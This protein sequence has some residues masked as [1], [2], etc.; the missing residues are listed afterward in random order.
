M[1]E[2]G[3]G[4]PAEMGLHR[5]DVW[6][7]FA[8]MFHLVDVFAVYAVTL[9]GGR[10]VTLPTFTPQEALLAIGEL[11]HAKSCSRS[12]LVQLCCAAAGQTHGTLH[13]SPLPLLPFFRFVQSVSA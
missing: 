2:A 5:G 13:A 6:G 4:A 3:T 8:P 10:H 7:H 12:S 9:V 11:T 1:A